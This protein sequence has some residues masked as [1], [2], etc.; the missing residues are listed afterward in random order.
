MPVDNDEDESRTLY[1]QPYN[2]TSTVE[3]LFNELS[4]KEEVKRGLYK[5]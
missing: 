5:F 1:Q 2:D 3:L 4:V